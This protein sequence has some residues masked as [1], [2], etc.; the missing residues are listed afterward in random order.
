MWLPQS[1]KKVFKTVY[2]PKHNFTK[3]LKLYLHF[4]NTR[5]KNVHEYCSLSFLPSTTISQVAQWLKN[6]SANAGD[7]GSIPGLG[8]S[9]WSKK[10]QPTPKLLPGEFH[11]QRSLAGYSSWG[12]KG[13]GH[14]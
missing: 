7:M 3:I 6:Q 4:L 10:W 11:G 5:K 9:P 2:Q 14:N 1:N 8:K 13:V 12:R